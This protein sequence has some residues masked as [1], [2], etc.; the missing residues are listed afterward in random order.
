ML[1]TEGY[2]VEF[3]VNNSIFDIVRWNINEEGYGDLYI[4]DGE[5]VDEDT[6]WSIKSEMENIPEESYLGSGVTMDD[7]IHD[8][9]E[10]IMLE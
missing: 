2:N 9:V 3:L 7:L 8:V 5:A 4:V 1:D 10:S 6:F